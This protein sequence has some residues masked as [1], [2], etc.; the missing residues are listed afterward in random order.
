MDDDK[1]YHYG[2]PRHSGRYPWG[3]GKDPYQSGGSMLGADK[4]YQKKGMTKTERAHAMGYSRTD[5]DRLLSNAHAEQ[6]AAETLQWQKLRDKGWSYQAIGERYGVPTSTIISRLKKQGAVKRVS[7]TEGAANMLKDRLEEHPYIDVSPGNE[8]F[9]N[10]SQATFAKALTKLNGDGYKIQEIYIPQVTNPSQYTTIKVLSKDGVERSEILANKDKIAI[11]TDYVTN[12]DGRSW[13]GIQRPESVSSDRVMVKYAEDGGVDK[14]GVIEIRRGVKDLAIGDKNYAQ[15][16]IAVDGTHY[17]KG[18]AIYSDA[19]DWPDGVDIVFNSNKPKGMPMISPDKDNSVLKPMKKDKET[20]DIDW[21]NPFGSLIKIEGGVVVGQHNYIGDDGKEHL[22]AVNIVKEAGDWNNWSKTLSSQFLSK[23]YNATIK[24]Q[25]D[26]SYEVK[27]DQFNEIMELTSPEVKAKL[28]TE[29]A[30]ECDSAAVHLKAAALP[31]QATKVILPVPG[32]K[33]NEVY[34]PTYNDGEQV[35]LVRH[36][37]E[38]TFQIPTLT[39]NNKS[40]DGQT[41]VG[42]DAID[43]IG[44][45]PKAAQQLSGA[46]FDGDTVIVIPTAGQKLKSEKILKDLDG[47]DP[48]SAYPAYEGMPRVGP[49][50]GFHKQTEMGKISNLITDMTIIGADEHEIA[51]AVRHSMT[52]IDAEK[53]NLDW[54]GSFEDNRI[55]EL[56]EKYQGGANKGASTLISKASSTDWVD[57]RK[58]DKYEYVD[59]NGKTKR[60]EFNPETGEKTYTNTGKTMQR[61]VDVETGK[62]VS[63]AIDPETKERVWRI[64]KNG[65]IVDEDNVERVD[66][67][68]P[69]KNKSSKMAEAKDAYELSSGTAKEALYADYAN[70]LKTLAKKARLATLDIGT[71][72]YNPTAAKTYAKEVEELRAGLR[73]AESNAPFERQAQIRATYRVEEKLRANPEIRNDI[74]EVKKLRTEAITAA[75]NEVGASRQKRLIDITDRQWEAITAGALRPT[76]IKKVLSS[77]NPDKVKKLATPKNSTRTISDAQ[78]SRMRTMSRNGATLAEIASALGISSTTVYRALNE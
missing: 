67:D 17:L 4:Y 76:T 64:G 59:E 51:R 52:V 66:T 70:N 73:I 78:L 58:L 20:G 38:G 6:K 13:L 53:H 14:D 22:S 28:L 31:R 12:D 65:P 42:K 35:I 8:T 62:K 56:K 16:R 46:D 45:H 29:F 48:S 33:E 44:I 68:E 71:T 75:R 19:K 40:K 37:H 72:E 60:Y 50:T 32:L 69:K 2:T 1:L 34:A 74:D 61:F 5:Y 15:V 30:D 47:F 39:V 63:Y 55:A 23:Q 27:K 3:S 18:M 54:R 36:P 26:L 43:A 7:E 21:A 24:Q 10:I 25:L 41:I 77:A 49:D 9:L 57:D 11:V